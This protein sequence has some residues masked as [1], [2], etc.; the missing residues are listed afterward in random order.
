MKTSGTV[1][2]IQV[3]PVNRNAPRFNA[4]QA[5]STTVPE[6]QVVGTSVAR[7][8]ANDPDLGKII[9]I[10]FYLDYSVLQRLDWTNDK[11]QDDCSGGSGGGARDAPLA[12]FLHFHAVFGKSWR[13]T[14]IR[15]WIE[16]RHQ[17]KYG[18]C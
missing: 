13:P 8:T 9:S 2:S 5:F 16:L 12:K 14:W 11:P 1:V 18:W 17:I 10:L 4:N 3:A 6:S 15:H 7:V